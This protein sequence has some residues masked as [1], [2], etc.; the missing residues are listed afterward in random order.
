MENLALKNQ[1]VPQDV[2]K[3]RNTIQIMRDSLEPEQLEI[4][5]KCL[6]AEGHQYELFDGYEQ[7]P[8]ALSAPHSKLFFAS[9]RDGELQRLVE[10]IKQHSTTT[11]RVP[12]LLCI[13][14]PVLDADEELL[15]TSVDD[16]ILTP[17]NL[18]S[19]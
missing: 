17:L 18:K 4:I 7:I 10:T 15:L 5:T 9:A 3:I 2:V 14:H 1:T 6:E 8:Q 12:V 11:S 13:Q 19:L 16:F